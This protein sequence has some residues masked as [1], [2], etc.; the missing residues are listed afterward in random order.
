VDRTWNLLR[1]WGA[2]WGVPY[3]LED[4]LEHP[5]VLLPALLIGAALMFRRRPLLAL[6]AI[7][8]PI[9]L[10]LFR[11]QAGSAKRYI[12]YVVPFGMM[13]AATGLERV[14]ALVSRARP[15]RA[16]AVIA[17]AILIW[18]G[19]YV[20]HKASLYAL[21]VQNINFMQRRL[22]EM[23]AVVTKPEDRIAVNDIGAIG[24]FS[25][26]RV[27]DLMGLVTPLEPL[28]RALSLH[29]PALM[30]IFVDWFKDF[31]VYDS[32]QDTFTF[33]DADSTHKYMVVAGVELSVNTIC[34]RDQML[35]FR[36]LDRDAPPPSQRFLRRY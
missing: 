31:A 16:L 11:D 30:I 36:R 20:T 4:E 8:F 19:V 27:V 12:L 5:F 1:E 10:S 34:A 2:L 3:R 33:Y 14:S 6:Y 9:A 17:A 15:E 35:M 28:P 29:R 32:T 13:L 23:A 25:R 22:G 7:G 24:Y 21:N 18:Q 26:R